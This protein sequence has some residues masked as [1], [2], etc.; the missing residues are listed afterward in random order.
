M[1]LFKNQ[2]GIFQQSHSKNQ[3]NGLH[4]GLC[5]P[6][7]SERK[8][9]ESFVS[10]VFYKYYQAK[11]AEFY[12]LLLSVSTQH[13]HLKAVAGIRSA[14]KR[15]LFSEHYLTKPLH[16]YLE[17]HFS[18]AVSR[19][20][21]VEVGNLAPANVGQM[22]WLI[23]ALT[24]FLSASGFKVVVFTGVINVF[25]AFTR[26]GLP[27]IALEAA[28]LEKLPVPLR[29]QWTKSYYQHQPKVYIGDISLG[30][31]TLYENIN[32]HNPTLKSLWDLSFEQGL[33]FAQQKNQLAIQAL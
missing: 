31:D 29:D 2:H 33:N 16:N 21:I 14:D 1:M 9:L 23:T 18:Y 8:Q 10:K 6:D 28:S 24:A 32:K 20:E 15:T 12:P 25:N 27:L 30:V 17:S 3:H 11:I 4:V 26:M 19:H 22:R 13:N 7:N 5:F